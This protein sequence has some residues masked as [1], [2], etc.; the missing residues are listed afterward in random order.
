V[1]D[2]TP[3]QPSKASQALLVGGSAK[4]EG[5]LASS[6]WR[7]VAIAAGVMAVGIFFGWGWVFMIA[8]LTVMI[9][10]HE[11]GHF[12]T[13]KWAGMKVTEFCILGIGPKIWS[14]RR[15]ETEYM[16]RAIPVA[17][18]V[19]IIGMNNLDDTDPA[20][21]ARTFRQQSFP[22]RVVVMSGGSAMHFVQ[23]F[24]LFIVVFSVV[25]VP[26]D[27]ALAQKLGGPQPRWGIADLVAGGGAQKAG[28]KAGDELVSIAGRSVSDPEDVRPL[29][30]HR[31]GDTLPITVERDGQ[32]RT[33]QVTIG[34]DPEEPKLGLMGVQVGALPSHLQPTTRVNPA[35]AAWESASTMGSWSW[36]TLKGLGSFATGGLGDYARQVVGHD[37]KDDEANGPVVSSSGSKG[38]AAESTSHA[39]NRLVSVFGV[40][41]AGA[42]AAGS[43]MAQVLLLLAIVNL[44]IG[45]INL[46]PLLP[47]DGGH[48][49][50]AVYERVRSRRGRRHM[51]DVSRL[52]PLTYAVVL[53]LGL[54]MVS[55]VYLDIVDPVGLR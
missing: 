9:F 15:G 32:Q 54:I 31:A 11:L 21:E 47:F 45:I 14:T 50:V 13:A 3:R 55:S 33:F 28:M 5:E 36:Q 49:A 48:I 34:H 39:D 41:R 16:V 52:L 29:V 42:D 17:A 8:A 53:V 6:P 7:L 18:Y 20:D 38:H 51:A 10:L 1:T 26:S 4:P 2:P 40:A 35:R 22:K 23:A 37:G 43:D 30:V 19:R 25:G 27:M 44:S 24:I 12:L 46:L